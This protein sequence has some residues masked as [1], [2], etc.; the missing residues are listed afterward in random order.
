MHNINIYMRITNL[1]S[2]IGV[3]YFQ[4]KYWKYRIASLAFIL[5]GTHFSTDFLL[6]A[7]KR[8]WRYG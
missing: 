2:Y 6:T 1:Q 7:Q 8:Y 4:Y 3:I 5:N